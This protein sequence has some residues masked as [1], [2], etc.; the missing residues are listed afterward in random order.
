MYTKVYQLLL[1]FN[2][3]SLSFYKKIFH[4]RRKFFPQSM[5]FRVPLLMRSLKEETHRHC[6]LITL[7][8]NKRK[9]EVEG[10]G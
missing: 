3:K 7:Y 6:E 4:H 10:L 5:C 8:I 1:V 9:L 2:L